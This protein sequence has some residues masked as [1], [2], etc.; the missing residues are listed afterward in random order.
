MSG[1]RERRIAELEREFR[2]A[3][4]PNLI[5]DYSARED[6]FTRA[7]PFLTFVFLVELLNALNDRCS[8]SAVRLGPDRVRSKVLGIALC[9]SRDPDDRSRPR[10]SDVVSLSGHRW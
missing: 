8:R 4:L 6:I 10:A 3:G 7:L 9:H 1:E 2:R 5:E